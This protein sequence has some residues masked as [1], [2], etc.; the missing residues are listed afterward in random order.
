MNAL[1]LP[2]S[3]PCFQ[4]WQASEGDGGAA[5]RRMAATVRS[6]L[7]LDLTFDLGDFGVGQERVVGRERLLDFRQ[8]S[9]SRNASSQW[10]CLVLV[11]VLVRVELAGAG[12]RAGASTL[13][14]IRPR[15]LRSSINSQ[16]WSAVSDLV[17]RR[18]AAWRIR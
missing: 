11:P 1:V 14:L 9:T 6:A 15:S 3:P 7:E 18:L 2:R 5:S 8:S 4:E 13:R 10:A 17:R 16:Y 12:S